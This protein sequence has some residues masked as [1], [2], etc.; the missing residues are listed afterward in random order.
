MVS[1]TTKHFVN[2]IIFCVLLKFIGLL[3][4]A[5]V[6]LGWVPKTMVYFLITVEMGIIAIVTISLVSITRYEARLKKER[7]ALSKSKL[8]GLACPDYHTFSNNICMSNYTTANGRFTYTFGS[9]NNVALE[10]FSGKALDYACTYA[11]YGVDYPWTDMAS[12]CSTL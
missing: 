7:D 9:N 11:K 3:L 4:M 12:K 5:L 2:T 8:L 10:D 1:S 6:V